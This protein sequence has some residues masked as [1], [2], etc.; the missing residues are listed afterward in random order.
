MA[1]GSQFKIQLPTFDQENP[2]SKAGEITN[3]LAALRQGD[4]KA[5]S[6][7]AVLIY[8]DL[9]SRAAKYM[10]RERAD[11]TL[12]PTA[13]VNETFVWL[14]RHHAIEWQNR[15]HFFATASVVMRRIL[16]DYAR[17][18]SANKRPAARLQVSLDDHMAAETP[19]IEQVLVLD[20]ALTRLTEMDPRQGRLVELVYFGGLTEEESAKVLGVSLRT[21]QREWRSAR[22]WLQA[23]LRRRPA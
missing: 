19:R 17:H 5:E 23:Q 21:V 1:E 13:L 22:A 9:H 16:V 2:L 11:H 20:E 18:R 6:N 4:R 14:M 10:R 3:L 8:D 12:Q 7:L 15:A